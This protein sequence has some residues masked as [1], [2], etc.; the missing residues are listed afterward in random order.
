MV[1]LQLNRVHA[2]QRQPGFVALAPRK[3]PFAETGD[4]F[5]AFPRQSPARIIAALSISRLRLRMTEVPSLRFRL[6]KLPANVGLFD[7]LMIAAMGARA[8]EYPPAALFE[9]PAKRRSGRSLWR[10]L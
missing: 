10:V 4:A 2:D 8:I 1:N 9:I 6:V 5:G 7:F 3:G